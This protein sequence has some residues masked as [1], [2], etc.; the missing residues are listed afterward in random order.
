MNKFYYFLLAGF[1][2]AIN[3]YASE[4]EKSL[5]DFRWS[6]LIPEGEA[7][8]RHECNFVEYKDKFYLLGG[9]GDN[10]VDVYDPKTNSWTNKSQPPLEINHFQ[11]VVYGD[12]I[13]V[14]C[15][16]N[17]RY[18]VEDPFTNVWIYYPEDDRWEQ[19]DPI[20]AEHQ[21]GGAGTVVY[22]DKIY[23]VAGVECGHTSG[24]T[25]IFSSYDPRTGEWEVLTKA[26]HIRDHFAAI[27]VGDKLYCIGGR[28]SSEHR[29]GAFKTFFN[30]VTP[31]VDV[32]DFT[33]GKWVTLNNNLPV[34]TAAGGV[35]SVG[36]E[37]IYFGGEGPASMAYSNTQCLNTSTGE[38]RELSPMFRGSHG[39]GAV[40]YEGVVYWAGGSYKQGGSNTSDLQIF[41]LEK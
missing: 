39:S 11:S 1:L 24:T 15:A 13:Y 26:P 5:D 32:Y 27:V 31:E 9:R 3:L 25:N 35:V 37:I 40:Y 8:P 21:R 4:G 33:T 14:V 34:A 22:K 7:Q 17:G 29:E 10:T 38:W 6:E 20:P 23:V 41:G 19:G 36:A 12:A 18:P 16:M 30:A 28:N 2:C